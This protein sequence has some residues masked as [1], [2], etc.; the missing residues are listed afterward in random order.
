MKLREM[1]NQSTESDADLVKE[2]TW[3]RMRGKRVHTT[4]WFDMLEIRIL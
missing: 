4:W 3:R 2:R 1:I